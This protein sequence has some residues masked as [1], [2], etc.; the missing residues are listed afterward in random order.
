[1]WPAGRIRV[2]VF[3][4]PSAP[5]ETVAK[6]MVERIDEDLLPSIA[7]RKRHSYTSDSPEGR[8]TTAPNVC[9]L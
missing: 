4:R 5:S 9:N 3:T 1:M 7:W 6:Q 8:A 2:E